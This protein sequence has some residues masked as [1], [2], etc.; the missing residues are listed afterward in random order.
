[1]GLEDFYWVRSWN[2]VRAVYDELFPNDG[3]KLIR[4]YVESYVWNV[5][6]HWTWRDEGF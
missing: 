6:E 2:Q 3:Y 1:M 4:F 5:V